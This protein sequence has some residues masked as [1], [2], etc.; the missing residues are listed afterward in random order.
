MNCSRKF[1]KENE[2]LVVVALARE[3]SDLKAKQPIWDFSCEASQANKTE[4]QQ[5]SK[6]RAYVVR[7]VDLEARAKTDVW[8][9]KS[10]NKK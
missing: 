8:Y 3:M 5:K 1:S 10:K 2:K 7:V 4:Y 6:W 9:V